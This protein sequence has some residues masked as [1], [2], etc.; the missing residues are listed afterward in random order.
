MTAQ[1]ATVI[2]LPDRGMLKAGWAADVV[3]FDPA[4]VADRATYEEPFQYPAGIKTVVINGVV[5]LRDE[6][7]N[8][9]MSGKVLRPGN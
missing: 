9:R 7:R 8:D 6:Q 3:V 2:K 4:T 5:A 1:P